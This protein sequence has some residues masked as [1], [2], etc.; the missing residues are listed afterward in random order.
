MYA[1]FIPHVDPNSGLPTGSVDLPHYGNG[2][3]FNGW[4]LHRSGSYERCRA[5][6][7]RL[8]Q[9]GHNSRLEKIG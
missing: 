1:V 7:K 5:E 2:A 9:A 8:R 3:T 6:H 4:K